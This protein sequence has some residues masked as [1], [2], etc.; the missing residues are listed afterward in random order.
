MIEGFDDNCLKKI[1]M[2]KSIC[3]DV[4]IEIEMN[5]RLQ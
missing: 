5:I 4:L 3:N 2:S 1:S